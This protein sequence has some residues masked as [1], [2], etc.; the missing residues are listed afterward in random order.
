MP[1]EDNAWDDVRIEEDPPL[2]RLGSQFVRGA[3][4][5]LMGSREEPKGV[6]ENVAEF[7]GGI[8]PTAIVSAV[9]S[10]I[11]G[12]GLKYAKI[13]AKAISLTSKLATAGITGAVASGVEQ[14]AD[15][16]DV[17]LKNVALGTAGAAAQ[18]A[19]FLG[20]AKAF[21]ALRAPKIRVG[22]ELAEEGVQARTSEAIRR[23]EESKTAEAIEDATKDQLKDKTIEYTVPPEEKEKARP[24]GFSRESTQRVMDEAETRNNFHVGLDAE[25]GVNEFVS[26]SSTVDTAIDMA[27][28]TRTNPGILSQFK[29]INKETAKKL[30]IAGQREPSLTDN[31]VKQSEETAKLLVNSENPAKIADYLKMGFTPEHIEALRI[32]SKMGVTEEHLTALQD[33]VQRFKNPRQRAAIIRKQ[34]EKW[35]ANG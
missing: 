28:R 29:A 4:Y 24:T 25:T 16:G 7:A 27:R 10:P 19:L 34:L 17:S 35:C 1:I 5:G 12:A 32:A 6:A 18:E 31:L 14:Y 22:A 15:E 11:V 30:D 23:R 20:G 2:R 13:P 8:I 9:A 26:K 33:S 21:K 3:T